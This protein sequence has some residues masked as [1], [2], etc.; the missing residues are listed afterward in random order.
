MKA[1]LG[2]SVEQCD[3]ILVNSNQNN[4][5]IAF[6]KDNVCLKLTEDEE[7]EEAEKKIRF[8][9][10]TVKNNSPESWGDYSLCLDSCY[11][12]TQR[13]M[14]NILGI[15]DVGMHSFYDLIFARCYSEFYLC[16]NEA[17]NVFPK[18]FK[19]KNEIK[20]EL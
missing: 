18:L 3:K 17:Y 9:L 1:V 7:D 2:V 13:Y 15:K 11:S 8:M 5:Y 4:K 19:E 14:F 12:V 20:E 16:N 10:C 6:V